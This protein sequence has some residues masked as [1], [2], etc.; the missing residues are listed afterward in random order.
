[1]FS[2]AHQP[3]NNRVSQTLTKSRDAP[4]RSI[5]TSDGVELEKYALHNQFLPWQRWSTGQS[6]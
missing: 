6:L 1:M 2:K 5:T 3:W 4:R